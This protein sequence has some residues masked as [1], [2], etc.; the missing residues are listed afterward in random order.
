MNR[1]LF[2]VSAAA[3]F[4]LTGCGGSGGGTSAIDFANATE[5]PATIENGKEVA[6]DVTGAR[7]NMNFSNF[8]NTVSQPQ[9]TDTML[10]LTL[11]EQVKTKRPETR[12]LNETVNEQESCSYGGTYSITGS[13]NETSG[14]HVTIDIHNC[15][16][17]GVVING[18][19]IEDLKLNAGN[20]KSIYS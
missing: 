4:Y 18:K 11:L 9:G 12:L 20:L 16:E 8:L 13:R 17:E 1:V 6:K 2:S 14:G 10:A 15:N 7:T 3:L 5:A 19:I